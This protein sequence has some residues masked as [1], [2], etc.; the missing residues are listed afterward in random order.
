M[1]LIIFVHQLISCY[2]EKIQ[3]MK[4]ILLIE[5]NTDIRENAAEILSL[6]NYKV[7]TAENGKIGLE[8]ALKEKPDLIICDIMMPLLDG[9]GVLHALQRNEDTALIP[10]IFLTAKTERKEVRTGMEMG[11]D[12]YITK[13]FEGAELLKAV[14]GRLRKAA[15]YSR[16]TDTGLSALDNLLSVG[17]SDAFI[18]QL[19]ENRTVNKY[20]K[21]QPIYTA[22]N[23]PYRLYYL[24]SGK[25]K[26]FKSN[27]DAKELITGLYSAGDFFG[28]NALLEESNY[29]DSAEVIE[30]AEIALIPREDF[31]HILH[32]NPLAMRQFVKILAQNLSDRE[33]Q[34]MNMAY[35]SLRKKVSQTLLDVYYKFNTRRDESY[36]L[37]ISRDNLAGIA[38][39]ATESLIRT[40]SDFKAEKLID[41]RN[42]KIY[43]INERKLSQLLN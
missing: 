43:I 12:D 25:V 20:R 8:I 26:S 23:H 18:K 40:L 42:G 3:K 15:I 27:E 29:K 13:P 19:T 22:G 28:Y 41:I 5:D 11:A 6:S 1:I 17:K 31:V 39:T 33:T 21:K 35:N 4:T 7:I 37:E 14:D 32:Q 36:F 2:S 16:P 24:I 34:L 9:Y 38:G 10:F 30:D